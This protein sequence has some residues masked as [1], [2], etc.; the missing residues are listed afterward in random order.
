MKKKS[1]LSISG[2]SKTASNI[3]SI[4]ALIEQH[5]CN[6]ENSKM[7]EFKSDFAFYIHI[8]G[9][10]N[11]IFAVE[12]ELEV[13]RNEC[14]DDLFVSFKRAEEKIKLKSSE[15]DEECFIPYILQLM[16]IDEIGILYKITSFCEFQEIA[17]ADLDIKTYVN[18]HGFAMAHLKI[19]LKIPS[20]L[21]ITSLREQFQIFCDNE[22]LDAVLE[23]SVY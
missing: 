20:N 14:C 2:I 11:K 10:W 9:G 21:N 19:I 7:S 23:A 4:I 16:T 6:I 17:I 8:S 18:T 3:Y 5:N 1:F 13:L 22:N 15:E 12:E